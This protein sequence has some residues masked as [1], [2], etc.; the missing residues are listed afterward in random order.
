M[1]NILV[2]H[3]R[4]NVGIALKAIA[5]GGSHLMFFST[6]RGTPVGFPAMPVIK[7]ASNTGVY[8][9]MS[10]DIDINAG[11]LTEGTQILELRDKMIQQMIRISNGEKTILFPC[12]HTSDATGQICFSSS[13]SYN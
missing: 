7:V 6:G 3:L 11:V 10:D 8:R 13:I 1:D 4:D 9:A 2:V 5:A 12:Y